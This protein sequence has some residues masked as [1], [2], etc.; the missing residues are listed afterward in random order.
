[1][2]EALTVSFIQSFGYSIY[3]EHFLDKYPSKAWILKGLSQNIY[4]SLRPNVARLFYKQAIIDGFEASDLNA[5][6]LAISTPSD[7]QSFGFYRYIKS[8]QISRK[9]RLR[10]F[11]NA[12]VGK[13]SLQAIYRSLQI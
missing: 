11:K 2:I 6:F 8:N 10:I 5:N 9:D 13:D 12:L 3:G 7:A 1:M 4:V